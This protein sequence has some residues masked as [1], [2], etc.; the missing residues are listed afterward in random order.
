MTN[1]TLLPRDFGEWR[2]SGFGAA[3][4]SSLEF[5]TTTGVISDDAAWGDLLKVRIRTR[6]NHR[7]HH[8]RPGNWCAS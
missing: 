3:A 4:G 1:S 2:G 5:Y 7:P 8:E 6:P